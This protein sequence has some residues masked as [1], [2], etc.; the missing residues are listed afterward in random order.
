MKK[1]LLTC[2]GIAVALALAFG[3]W[4]GFASFKSHKK[5]HGKET[6]HVKEE[7][8]FVIIIPSYNNSAF[9]EKNLHSVFEQK[10]QNFRVIYIDD[11]STDDTFTK[12]QALVDKA[13]QNQRVTLL[14]NEKNRGSL[15]NFYYA[16]HSCKDN[17]IIV[18]LDGDDFLAHELVLAKLNRV[19]T[20]ENA[21]LTYGNYLD[22]PSFK[23]EV[24][25]CKKIAD[26][27]VRQNR[28]R[29]A[30]WVS[31]HLRTFY[32]SLFKKIKLEDFLYNGRFYPMAGDLAMMYPLLE[33]AGKHS[34]FIPDVLYLYNR[35]NPLN[36]H[37]TNFVLQQDCADQVRNSHPYSPLKE[38]PRAEQLEEKAD[39]VIFSYNRPMQLYALLE[40]AEKFMTGLNKTSVLFR[41]SEAE[42]A[43]GYQ[44]VKKSFPKVH[45]IQQS[46][47]PEKDFSPLLF[48]VAFKGS[49][50][51][52]LLFA[53]DD[54]VVKDSVDLKDCIRGL[55]MTHAYGFYLA[56]G[57]HLN[58]CFMQER[59]QKI[60][61][62]LMV[63]NDIFC[64]K[65]KDGEADWNYP[66]S[67]DM[68]LYRKE[69]VIK[70]L[71]SIDFNNPNSLESEWAKLTKRKKLGLFFSR[72]RCLNIP[73][74][75]VNQ[76]TNRFLHSHT[77]EELLQKF[78]EGQKIDISPF[79]HIENA[80]KHHTAEISFIPRS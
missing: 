26:S 3:G 40:S 4:Q 33:M 31:S 9:C 36:D 55:E 23:Q 71:K 59:R 53:V 72:S 34:V 13:G 14:H 16:I 21:W 18:A 22:Y 73:L 25:T 47:R 69:D 77:S 1:K 63:A 44:V 32:A 67:V 56:H 11:C 61:P 74:N 42:F 79:F 66:N 45:F 76:S 58:D 50:A 30:P 75:L 51:P 39:L 28:F 37:K 65:F 60:P 80:S 15:A 48:E 78:K 12:V 70:D 19:Y 41:A 62:N 54:N 10:Y 8:P 43:E 57:L 38:L 6:A 20:K 35:T 17:E 24:V 64:W 7:L 29:K 49:E 68:V 2:L 5:R 27:V 46:D 52:Y